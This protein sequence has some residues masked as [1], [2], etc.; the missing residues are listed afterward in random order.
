VKFDKAPIPG[1]SGGPVWVVGNG[2]SIG[3]L[4]REGKGG[5]TLVEPLLHPKGMRAKS[6][7]GIL[8]DKDI[9]PLNLK[10]AGPLLD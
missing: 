8:N 10:T 5:W 4:S 7:P 3:L 1:D 2:G 6:V 9:A